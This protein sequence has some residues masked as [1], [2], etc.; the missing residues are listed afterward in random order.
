MISPQLSLGYEPDWILRRCRTIHYFLKGGG[1]SHAFGKG[2]VRPTH[3]ADDPEWWWHRARRTRAA[4]DR[5]TDPDRKRAMTLIVQA[6]ERRAV[7]AEE[8][9]RLRRSIKPA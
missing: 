4:V 2:T 5:E 3:N 8:R 9:I 6:Y 7:Q 1:R